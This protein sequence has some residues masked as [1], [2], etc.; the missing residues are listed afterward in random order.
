MP[1]GI[2][3]I[4][5]D[6]HKLLHPPVVCIEFSRGTELERSTAQVPIL[7]RENWQLEVGYLRL[8]VACRKNWLLARLRRPSWRA[9]AI[10]RVDTVERECDKLSAGPGGGGGG[11]GGRP[12]GGE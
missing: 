1:L 12:G 9:C 3:P 5:Y 11:G 6:G 7:P 4:R 10:R 2:K 8:L